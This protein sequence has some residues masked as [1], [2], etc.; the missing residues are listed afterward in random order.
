MSL[1][2]RCR[3]WLAEV[4]PSCQQAARAQSARLDGSLSRSASLGLWIHLV[5]CRW[6]RRYGR[7]IRSIREQMKK[8]PEKAHAG[9]PDALRSEA[10]ERLKEILRKPPA[11]D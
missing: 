3:R 6:C 7:Q 1:W 8:H 2:G 10:K 9:V 4:S 5:L 11:E